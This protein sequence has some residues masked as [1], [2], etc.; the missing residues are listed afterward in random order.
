[1]GAELSVL[2]AILLAAGPQGGAETPVRLPASAHNLLVEA[3]VSGN[4]ASY[5]AGLRGAADHV[6]FDLRKRRFAKRSQWHEY[7]VGF[8]KDLGVVP[9]DRPAFWMAEWPKPVRA[10]LIVLSGVYPNQP[11]PQ[12]CWRIELRRDGT[13][14]THA[15]GKG[16][17]YDRGRYVWCGAGTKAIG[18]DA[19][20][21]AVFSKDGGSP[22]GS[23]HFRGEE[24]DSWVV[25][26]LPPID[27][28]LAVSGRRARAGGHVQL[29]PGE[30]PR[31]LW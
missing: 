1:M 14:T 9:E 25:A 15:R 12:T 20:R 2:A 26:D 11:Q 29:L 19:I 28:R 6:V 7:G 16:G 30:E 4:L 10:N 21:V 3:K 27:A 13:W 18:F 23:I 5:E 24:G 22:I 17:W 31:C 8:G